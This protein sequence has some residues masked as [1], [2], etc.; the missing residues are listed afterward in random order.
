MKN[1]DLT[2]DQIEKLQKE[3]LEKKEQADNEAKKSEEFFS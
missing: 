2:K 3:T 1:L